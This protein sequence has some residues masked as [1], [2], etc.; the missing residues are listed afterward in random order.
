M[1]AL[2]VRAPWWWY[3]L[4]GGKDIENR[5]WYTN[6]RGRVLLHAGKSWVREDIA[7]DHQAAVDMGGQVIGRETWQ[8]LRSASGCLVGSVEIIGCVRRSASRWFMGECGFV[9]SNP[10][11]FHTPIP[12]RGALGFFDVPDVL[13]SQ[14]REMREGATA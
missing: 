8:A 1:K 13:V 11:A 12:Y 7:L 6:V 5:D 10:I 3:I 9:L 4:H 14:V 2:S